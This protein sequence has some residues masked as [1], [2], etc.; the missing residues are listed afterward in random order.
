MSKIRKNLDNLELK[1]LEKWTV[2]TDEFFKNYIYIYDTE[3][4]NLHNLANHERERER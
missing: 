2:W 1:D 4:P 3:G